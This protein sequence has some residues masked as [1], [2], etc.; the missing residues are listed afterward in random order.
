[1]DNNKESL[2]ARKKIE[3]YNSL[4]GLR[5]LSCFSIIAMHIALN[6]NYQIS[7]FLW[8]RFIPSLTWLVYLFLIISGF[9]MCAG[10]L[11]RFHNGTIDLETFYKRRYTK[12]LPFLFFLIALEMI[13][14]PSVTNLYEG[15]IEAMLMHGLLPNNEMNVLGVSWTLGVIFLFYL[16]FPFFTVLLKTKRRAWLTLAASLWLSFI[17]EQY[18][19]NPYFVTESFT[20]RHSFLYCAPLFCGG[21]IAY[22]YRYGIKKMCK[23]YRWIVLGICIVASV[24]YY[25]IPSRG[26]N[27]DLTFCKSFILFMLWF[28]YAVGVD[29]YLLSNKIVR[30]FGGISM[31][32]YLAHMVIFRA[33]EK[34]RLLYIFGDFGIKGWISYI[35]VFLMVVLGL[36]L[37]I[38]VYKKVIMYF[39]NKIVLNWI[40]NRD[41]I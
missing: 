28:C 13:W 36:V 40:W 14:E 16:L 39:K 17:C 20:P 7:G 37:L 22:L 19:F 4:D 34:I 6:T 15:S 29:S 10:Y 18:F 3:Y 26:E 27:F 33:I 31:E 23:D 11:D 25:A 2:Q 8:D 21:G 9:G 38:Q 35:T 41:K 12:I 24:L 1:M 32:M 5:T 30:F